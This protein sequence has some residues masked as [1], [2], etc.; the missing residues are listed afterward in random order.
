MK[1]VASLPYRSLLF[2]AT[3]II[4]VA[5]TGCGSGSSAPGITSTTINIGSVLALRGPASGLGKGMSAGMSAAMEGQQVGSRTISIQYRNDYY[6]KDQ[7]AKETEKLVAQGIFLM[8]GNVGTPTASVTLPILQENGVPAV[9][10]FTGAGI[11]RPGQG[12]PILNYRASYKQEVAAVIDAAVAV[13]L[14]STQICAY[15]QND[16]YGMAGLAGVRDAMRRHGASPELLRTYDRIIATPGENPPR[17]G[18]GPVGV[19]TRNTMEVASGYRSLKAWE[20][21][22]GHACKLV[23][24]VGAYANIANM[25][26]HASALEPWVFSAVSFTGAGNLADDLRRYGYKDNVIMTQVVPLLDSNLPIVREAAEKLGSD[27]GFVSFE[28]YIVGKMILELLNRVDGPLTR[29]NFVASAKEASFD[30]GGLPIDFTDD[31]NQGSDL[32]VPSYLTDRG[33]QGLTPEAFR[34]MLQL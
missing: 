29:E 2:A 27:F 16:G 14:K 18:F 20:A 5:L 34:Q 32:V 8:A 21:E 13:G 17:N 15:V 25:V 33:W 1:P 10:F 28:G 9:G 4:A 12:G 7:A 19:Y 24:T 26:R 11:L 22:S 30:L 6:E 3:I 23:V 31:G